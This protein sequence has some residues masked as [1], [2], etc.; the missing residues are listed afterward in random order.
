M[1]GFK[2][3]ARGVWMGL[4]TTFIGLSITLPYIFRRPYTLQYPEELPEIPESERGLHNFEIDKCIAC[5]QCAKI[6]PVDC[7]AI[8]DEIRGKNGIVKKFEI[9][10]T[11]CLFCALCCEPCPTECI[12]MGPTFD[13]VGYT[14]EEV[15]IDYADRE[16]PRTFSGEEKMPY[17]LASLARK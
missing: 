1:I 9:D 4:K 13:L 6:C 2:E 15:I 7:I 12:H 8:E 17:P 3:W 16:N 10:Y 11:K 14:R 5:Y